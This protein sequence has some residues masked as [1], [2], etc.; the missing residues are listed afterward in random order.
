VTSEIQQNRYDQLLRRVAGIIGPGSKVSEVLTELFPVLDV[1]NVPAELLVLAGTRTAMA[2]GNLTSAAGE[3]VRMGVF[4]PAGSGHLVI[5]TKVIVSFGATQVMRWG[6]NTNELTTQTGVDVFTDTRMGLSR[7]VGRFGQQSSVALAPA[8]G[9]VV[10]E[11]NTAFNLLNIN[12]LMVLSP[13]N[14]FDLGG[15]SSALTMR[16]AFYWRERPALE[17]EL[18]LP[19]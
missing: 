9:S 2:G 8:T 1:E 10:V 4:N 19:G 15:T 5:V 18:N 17:S 6:R 16:A 3:G 14:G 13:G 12:E 11:S 7:P